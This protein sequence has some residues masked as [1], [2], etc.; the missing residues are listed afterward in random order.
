MRLLAESHG[1]V[2]VASGA[3]VIVLKST[4]TTENPKQTSSSSSS[5]SN[6]TTPESLNVFL[7]PSGHDSQIVCVT[8]SNDGEF[9]FAGY[10]NKYICCWNRQGEILGSFVH[11]KRPTGLVSAT[12]D[13]EGNTKQVLI[14]SDKVGMI[15]ATDAPTFRKQTAIAGHTASV[16]TD[17]IGIGE[18]DPNST[19]TTAY[20]A[21]ADRDE[22][23]R[24]SKFPHM[25]IIHSFCLGHTNVITSIATLRSHDPTEKGTMMLLSTGWDHRL[26][27]WSHLEGKLLD[28]VQYEGA[29]ESSSG[30]EGENTAVAGE[31][32]TTM[33]LGSDG[34]EA[35]T[36]IAVPVGFE[37]VDEEEEDIAA[38]DDADL[39]E[40]T[41]DE[42]N[43]GQ[44]PIKVITSS[45]S[46]GVSTDGKPL[47]INI[48]AVIFK[49]KK[50]LK[51]YRI[52]SNCSTSSSNGN[53]P[54]PHSII[55]KD[56][57]EFELPTSP[58]DICFSAS[59]ELIVLLAKP[60]YV[61]YLM[62]SFH[63]LETT[64]TTSNPSS[65]S[66]S[67]LQMK[68]SINEEIQKQTQMT[69]FRA[70]CV[71]K[72]IDF[73]QQLVGQE[74]GGDG[75]RGRYPF[76]YVHLDSK[77]DPFSLPF[78]SSVFCTFPILL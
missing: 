15:Y 56:G 54:T 2:Y 25:E 69:E 44:F 13:H 7:F 65:S 71:D 43:A 23:I 70:L 74:G 73:A 66:S 61:T 76:S 36:T 24:I 29:V 26:C 12:I 46:Y 18:D 60:H 20:I 21:T 59:N 6:Q 68:V 30:I 45:S 50:T 9:I 35:A 22:K 47:S 37:E 51:V 8:V 39:V 53:D 4:T 32:T 14:I 1:T 33:D 58:S 48:A 40:K 28:M 55:D 64:T 19:N 27:L 38:V 78:F 57:V 3:F 49:N 17:M 42:D 63:T 10:A 11:A 67:L 34:L 75:E 77:R 52:E 16:I 31:G 62:V 5:S 41:Y 72:D